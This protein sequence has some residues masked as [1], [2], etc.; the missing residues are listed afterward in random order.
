MLRIFFSAF[1]FLILF[2]SHAQEKKVKQVIIKKLN[3][4]GQTESTTFEDYNTEGLVIKTSMF[5][6]KR[7]LIWFTTNQYDSLGRVIKET[8]YDKNSS[9]T[10]VWSF[11]YNGHNDVIE[12]QRYYTDSKET[13]IERYDLTYNTL[14]L[15]TVSRESYKDGSAG[16][17]FRSEY[18]ASK[19]LT[20]CKT[21]F[22]DTIRNEYAYTYAGSLQMSQFLYDYE[23]KKLKRTLNEMIYYTYSDGLMTER[24]V[25][26]V[27]K[28]LD[29]KIISK[30]V[31]Q[32]NN[33]NRKIAETYSVDATL[34]YRKVYEYMYY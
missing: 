18:D 9:V 13:Y 29:K 28:H 19:N 8:S 20:N 21:Y 16:W 26:S 25:H 3:A 4:S 15:Q 12:Q 7:K 2:F 24:I 10:E 30:T 6:V 11:L 14:G 34:Q 5:D 23:N 33:E 31:Y 1:S 17:V 22:N 32:Y 27:A